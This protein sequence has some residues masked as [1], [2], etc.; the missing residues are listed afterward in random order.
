MLAKLMRKLR[1]LLLR[2]TS[3][4][5]Q[6]I[7]YLRRQGMRVGD[8]CRI[9]DRTVPAE[10]WL[11]QI[12]DHVTITD[13][14]RLL[15]HDGAV[16]L[17]RREHPEINR[18]APIRVGDNCF[19][20]ANAILL[21]GTSIGSDTI[22]AAG[23]VVRGEVPAGSVVGGVPARV[24]GSSADYLER[25]LAE[26]LPVDAASVARIVAGE[27]PSVV[28]RDLVVDSFRDDSSDQKQEGRQA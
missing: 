13:G 15:T 14:C 16:W 3:N 27:N 28:L 20:G 18:Y 21:P 25:A 8:G 19:I 12:G 23:S 22:V 24:L 1:F 7:E 4:D 26:S 9:I 17:A 10:P 2:A 5:Q 11:V 6:W